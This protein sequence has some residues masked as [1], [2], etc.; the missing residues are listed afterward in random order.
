VIAVF[1]VLAAVSLEGESV[2][3]ARLPPNAWQA[4]KISAITTD[5]FEGRL[6]LTVGPLTFERLIVLPAHSRATLEI[7]FYVPE[8]PALI[9]VSLVS[10]ER[11][12]FFPQV[13]EWLM[14][15]FR[16]EPNTTTASM[17][18]DYGATI[19]LRQFTPSA[20]LLSSFRQ[21]VLTEGQWRSLGEDWKA[22]FVRF[23]ATGGRLHV[24]TDRKPTN[25]PFTTY[26]GEVPNVMQRMQPGFE[27]VVPDRFSDV[28]LRWFGL[29]L[30]V[31]GGYLGVALLWRYMG[32]AVVGAV[33]GAC[34]AGCVA[35]VLLW[36]P[37]IWRISATVVWKDR[38]AFFCYAAGRYDGAEL[39]LK[40]APEGGVALIL[41]STKQ[42]VY[43][44]FSPKSAVGSVLLLAPAEQTLNT[45]YRYTCV[46]V[47]QRGWINGRICWRGDVVGFLERCLGLRLWWLLRFV[48]FKARLH[49][50]E[51]R[52]T[53]SGIRNVVLMLSG[54]GSGEVKRG[55]EGD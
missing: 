16:V 50:G 8:Q 45:E 54:L 32:R 5:A 39:A 2:F 23:L 4:A 14:T 29:L 48:D 27:P 12:E 34:C 36:A 38:F 42:I 33:L 28:G 22:A 25:V 51:R 53:E 24:L 40:G 46:V 49:E 35:A 26:G 41:P 44:G 37:R 9:K 3:A 15:A 6:R 43:E 11:E 13:A 19:R 21:I 47:G 1:F 7:P 17:N 55:G 52:I 18:G 31:A 10:A 20:F 30:I